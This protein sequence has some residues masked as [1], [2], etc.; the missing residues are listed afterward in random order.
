MPSLE[1]K[2]NVHCLQNY[3]L[4]GNITAAAKRLHIHRLTNLKVLLLFTFSDPL[5]FSIELEM[6][7]TAQHC[8]E[9]REGCR[10][11]QFFS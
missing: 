2:K 5:G 11:C 7:S 4:L 9:K 6:Q 8:V 10:T 1:E 3:D